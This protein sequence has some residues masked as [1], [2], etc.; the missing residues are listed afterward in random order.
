MIDFEDSASVESGDGWFVLYRAMLHL[1]L[2]TGDDAWLEAQRTML[3][4]RQQ[5][6]EE[7]AAAYYKILETKNEN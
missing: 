1:G 6:Q 2:Y 5:I 4:L 3:S 7:A